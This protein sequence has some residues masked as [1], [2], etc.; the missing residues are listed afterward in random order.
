MV[1]LESE[2]EMLESYLFLLKKRFENAFSVEID[3][4]DT[5][6]RNYIPPM[7][8]QLLVENALKHN[9]AE[10]SQPLNISIKSQNKNLIIE[11]NL[12]LRKDKKPSTQIGL[13]NL[14]ERYRLLGQPEPEIEKTSKYFRVTLP[15]LTIGEYEVVHH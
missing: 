10:S 15:L 6:K 2:L 4:D 8:L 9:V 1:S 5:S 7:S 13:S 11:N 3:V 12:Q 14:K